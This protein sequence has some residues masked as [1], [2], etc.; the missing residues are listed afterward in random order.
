MTGAAGATRRSGRRR[1]LDPGS[2][3]LAAG[4]ATS[5]SITAWLR[6]LLGAPFPRARRGGRGVPPGAD[7]LV[8]LPY[9]AGERTP[10]FDPDARGVDRRP[11][12]RHARGRPLPA[13]LEATAFGVAAQPRDDGRA[14]ADSRAVG[15]RR[16][17]RTRAVDRRSSPTSTGCARSC[18]AE[19]VGAC[20]G[21]A[22]LAAV[23][24]GVVE[25]TAV[26][27]PIEATIEPNQSHR[28][29]YDHLYE[30]YRQ[31]YADT[32]ESVHR[33]S[34]FQATQGGPTGG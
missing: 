7:G 10:L 12:V 31:V 17:H 20:Y 4:M 33:L 29:T 14:R 3:T 30:I 2:V 11:D 15:R 26:W 32:R 5:G 9:F 8:L 13:A 21:D 19:T 16:R 34:A 28:E 27:N 6:E 22:L 18:P 1:A 25:P 23:A 24:A